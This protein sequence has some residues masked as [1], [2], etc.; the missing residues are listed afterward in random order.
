MSGPRDDDLAAGRIRPPV[1]FQDS[2]GANFTTIR[3][4]KKMAR[5]NGNLRDTGCYA[6]SLR[7]KR[8]AIRNVGAVVVTRIMT[9]ATC[10]A[11]TSGTPSWR[12]LA[13]THISAMPPGAV[14][15][16]IVEIGT[17]AASATPHAKR[18]ETKTARTTE[19]HTMATKRGA[20][21]SDFR[22]KPDPSAHP[23]RSCAELDSHTG[24]IDNPTSARVS[25]TVRASGPSIQAFGTLSFAS[26]APAVAASTR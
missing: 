13:V 11:V 7:A 9:R 6:R 25:A 19:A 10:A 18:A 1:V 8:C 2:K 22:S 4:Q 24:I 15:S 3:S 26:S 17:A 5:K 16:T 20:V 14:A 23:S 21:L 12:T